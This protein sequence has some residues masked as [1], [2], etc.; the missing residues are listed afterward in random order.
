MPVTVEFY[1]VPRLRA[2]RA[3]L[4]APAGTLAEVMAHVVKACPALRDLTDH[5][6]LRAHY[7][8]SVEGERFLTEWDVMLCNGARVVVMSADAGG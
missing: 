5:P 6:S 8:V 1:G 4:E 3:T 2:G 7:L